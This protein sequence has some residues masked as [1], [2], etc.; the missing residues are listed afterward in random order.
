MTTKLN[1][2]TLEYLSSLKLTKNTRI[3]I[4]NLEK[5]LFD[6]KINCN[7]KINIDLLK[8]LL[9]NSL[10][11]SKQLTK[12]KIINIFKDNTLNEKIT[13]QII[14]PINTKSKNIQGSIILINYNNI[15]DKNSIKL[16]YAIKQ[17]IEFYLNTNN[18]EEINKF[19]NNPLYNKKYI[20][21]ISSL[22]IN[23]INELYVDN[24]FKEIDELTYYKIDSLKNKLKKTDCEL[25]DSILSLIDKKT[26]YYALYAIALG[27]NYKNIN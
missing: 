3:I 5:T 13:S 9:L 23:S 14:L 2:K 16:I 27:L 22:L 4:T 25:L 1:K 6:N 18:D 7:E 15:F 20:K 17:N 12:N 21:H 10:T 26:E 11:S 19:E 8:Y 24:G